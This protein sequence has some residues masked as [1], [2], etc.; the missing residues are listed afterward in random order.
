MDP[1]NLGQQ[2]TP[3]NTPDGQPVV[4]GAPAQPT[5]AQQPQGMV[6]PQ[7]QVVGPQQAQVVGPQQAPAAGPTM[8]QQPTDPMMGGTPMQPSM[9]PQG[10]PMQM[11]SMPAPGDGRMRR[12]LIALAALVLVIGIGAA[13]YFL[14]FKGD[15]SNDAAKKSSQSAEKSAVDMSTLNSVKLA[16]AAEDAT[17][18]TAKE[19][20][21]ADF[22]SF[23]SSDD[24][25]AVSVGIVKE[26]D[27]PGA[28][29]NAMLE[30]QLKALRDAGATID[31]PNA[32]K[33]LILKDAADS[34]TTYSMP[35]LIFD[36]S[37]DN[38]HVLTH[39]SA[40]ILKNTDRAVVS[41]ACGNKEGAVDK[42]KV[43]SLDD[44]AKKVKVTKQQ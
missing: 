17:G 30:P 39:Y 37:K 26:A 40:V 31:G 20:G 34:K 27:L 32:G 11:S 10:Q 28:D 5:P 4:G 12:M 29:L 15:S 23:S 44:I 3:T 41:R 13:V 25:C 8:P 6:T 1:N 18:L 16:L 43:N 2:N 36:F 24:M 38:Q 21:V 33:A 19:T 42:N 9:P 14:V 22:K 35:T 7:P